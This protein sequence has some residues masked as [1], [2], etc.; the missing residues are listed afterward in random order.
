M[1][2]APCVQVPRKGELAGCGVIQLG[3]V[4][5]VVANPATASNQ[6]LAVIEQGGCVVGAVGIHIAR[7]SPGL[8]LNLRTKKQRS[9]AKTGIERC[10]SVIPFSNGFGANEEE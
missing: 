2:N 4:L 8:C 6:D 7:E 10:L 5:V 1:V 9:E 3:G